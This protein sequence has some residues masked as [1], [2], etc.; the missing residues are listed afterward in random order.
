MQY[1]IKN[2]SYLVEKSN[3]YERFCYNIESDFNDFL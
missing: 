3:K 2:L 1:E